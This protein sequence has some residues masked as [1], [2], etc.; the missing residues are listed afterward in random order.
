MLTLQE[1]FNNVKI[2]CDEALMSKVQ[3]TAVDE[4]LGNIASNLQA[5]EVMLQAAKNEAK[6]DKEK[7]QPEDEPDET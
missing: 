4:S 5:H 1:S 2:I 7:P 6:A 3:R